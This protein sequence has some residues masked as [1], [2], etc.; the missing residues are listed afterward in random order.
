MFNE[1]NHNVDRKLTWSKIEQICWSWFVI[2]WP[3][4]VST[5]NMFELSGRHQIQSNGSLASFLCYG[6]VQQQN[7]RTLIA[8]VIPDGILLFLWLVV[9]NMF[10]FPI[11]WVANHPNWRTIFFRGVAL[12]HQPVLLFILSA[13]IMVI[14]P[15]SVAEVTATKCITVARWFSSTSWRKLE[16]A[17]WHMPWLEGSDSERFFGACCSPT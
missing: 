16:P 14:P 11:Y 15:P 13:W 4:G 2:F 3:E 10:Y 6:G 17:G 7:G 5:G 12:A 1:G 9:W 8:V